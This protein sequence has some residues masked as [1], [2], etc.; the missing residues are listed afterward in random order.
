LIGHKLALTNQNLK[1]FGKTG[2]GMGG[3]IENL[4]RTQLSEYRDP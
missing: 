4:L 1:D 3:V 2:L